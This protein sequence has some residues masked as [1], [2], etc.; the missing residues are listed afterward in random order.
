MLLNERILNFTDI[1]TTQDQLNELT[2]PKWKAKMSPAKYCTQ[3]VIELV[4]LITESNVKYRWWKKN[5]DSKQIDPWNVKIEVIDALHF[6]TSA[7]I[8]AIR[9]K[10]KDLTSNHQTEIDQQLVEIGNNMFLGTDIIS[11]AGGGYTQNIITDD[12]WV[13]YDTFVEMILDMS[14]YTRNQ[15]YTY[16]DVFRLSFAHL[17]SLVA[18]IG[19]TS[20]EVSA[21][22]IAKK[23]LNEIRQ[24]SGYKDGSYVKVENGVEDNQRLKS[25]VDDF[26]A[27]ETMT[28]N[29][30]SRNVR[31]HFFKSSK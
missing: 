19:L 4:E 20:L 14:V 31:N 26:I 13:D 9:E 29:K 6:L 3:A 11:L 18:S 12:G 28:L 30:L 16:L 5:D 1:L 8:L 2:V 10:T 24:S 15:D 22:Y 27:D 23:T 25:L 7:H 17:L 21:V